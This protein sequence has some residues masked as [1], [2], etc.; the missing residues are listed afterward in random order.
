MSNEKLR[1]TELVEALKGV[2]A[3]ELAEVDE[4]TL[5]VLSE[6]LADAADAHI[7]T[8][9]DMNRWADMF[10]DAGAII[11]GG[12]A[13]VMGQAQGDSRI[14]SLG[15]RQVREAL[16]AYEERLAEP[17]EEGTD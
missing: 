12:S 8:T 16:K 1:D 2:L 10:L 15:L 13:M 14:V 3:E 17:V 7:M 6:K 9:E 4:V 5:E 11:A